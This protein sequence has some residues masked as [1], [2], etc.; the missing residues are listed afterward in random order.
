MS[1]TNPKVDG[2][3]RKNSQWQN[4]LN[5]L[6]KIILT[7]ALTEEI[8][9]RVPCYT[10]NKKV[11]LFLGCFSKSAVLSFAKGALLNDPRQILIQQTENSQ[12]VRILRF[13]SLQEIVSMK[14]ALKAFIRQAVENETAGLKIQFKKTSEFKVPQEF[15]TKLDE[16]PALKAAFDSLTPGR[17][18]GYL[19]YFSQP[20]QS[21]TRDS[22]IEKCTPRILN[23]KGLDDD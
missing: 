18:R 17:Q 2:Y 23:G 15:Q 11:V 4:E 21:K 9:W 8:K 6:R 22:R 1:K 10:L 5:E 16:L 7:F 14:L 13:T 3:I 20:K 12:S 19:L